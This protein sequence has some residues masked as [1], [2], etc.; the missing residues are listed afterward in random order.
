MREDVVRVDAMERTRE[1]KIVGQGLEGDV[2]ASAVPA[3][4]NLDVQRIE[5]Q[6][7]FARY[8]S[9]RSKQH[10]HTSYDHMRFVDDSPLHQ[11]DPR[12]GYYLQRSKR[13]S[14]RAH[15]MAFIHSFPR[16]PLFP[17]TSDV[18]L[19]LFFSLHH[20]HGEKRKLELVRE[21]ECMLVASRLSQEEEGSTAYSQ[22]QIVT[23]SPCLSYHT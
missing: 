12:T 16:S 14:K 19:A 7:I 11:E 23:H 6:V 4:H 15:S 18:A 5:V 13:L 3:S 9:M 21:P 10:R 8:Q 22:S 1:L 2:T 17:F 20:N